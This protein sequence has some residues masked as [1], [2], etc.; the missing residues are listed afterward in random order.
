[1]SLL[2]FQHH[3]EETA[4]VLGA[5]LQGRGHRL[6]TIELFA[7]HVIPLDLDDVDGILSMG[8]PMNVGDTNYPWMAAEIDLIKAAHEAHLPVVGICLGAQILVA[9]LGGK[10]DAMSEPEA[11]FANVKLSFPGTIDPIQAGIP[12]NTMQF[13]LH[14]QQVIDLPPGGVPLAGSDRCRIQSFKVGF[15]TYGFQYH[16]EW[17]RC[18]IAHFGRNGLVNRSGFLPEAIAAQCDEHYDLYRHLG[19]RLCDN[20]T[21]LLFPIDKR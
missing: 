18:T 7:N 15:N 3:K 17:D 13:H 1:M 9:A 20:I 5:I 11:G 14:A 10:V 2:V 16:F 8:G 6:R 12:W 19:D 21:T 4:G